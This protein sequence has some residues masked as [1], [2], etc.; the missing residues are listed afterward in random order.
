MPEQKIAA[1]GAWVS[2]DTYAAKIWFCESPFCLTLHL[3]FS[4]GQL[5]YDSE[6]N[7]SFGP[8]KRPQLIGRT[9]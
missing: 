6:Y 4:G 7:V 5:F 2:Q 9:E 1:S 8:N 3:K